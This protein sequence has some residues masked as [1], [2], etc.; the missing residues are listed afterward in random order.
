MT[1]RAGIIGNTRSYPQFS[2]VLPKGVD[3]AV[4]FVSVI[5]RVSASR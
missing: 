3:F 2:S 1:S 5:I 4:A